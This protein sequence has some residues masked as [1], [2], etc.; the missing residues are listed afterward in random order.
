MQ[1]ERDSWL[2]Q[3]V[4]R[5]TLD[6]DSGHDL[7]VCGIEPHMGLHADSSGP[8]WDSHSLPPSLSVSLCLSLSLKINKLKNQMQWGRRYHSNILSAGNLEIIL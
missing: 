8:A 7:M 5:P 1:W 2:A 6:F 3:W 4:K